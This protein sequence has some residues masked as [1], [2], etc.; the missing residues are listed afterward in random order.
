VTCTA[1][2]VSPK[3]RN[4]RNTVTTGSTVARIAAVEGPTRRSP[5]KKKPM[6]AT[7]ETTPIAPSHTQPC[8]VT[9]PGRNCPSSAEP[10]VSVTAAP[11]HTSADSTYGRM[12]RAAPSLNKM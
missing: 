11:V 7:V 9:S 1:A 8:A 5:A 12:R 2:S 6:A 3:T 10:V 4:A